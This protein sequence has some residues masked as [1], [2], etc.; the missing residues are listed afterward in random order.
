MRV[1][2]ITIVAALAIAWTPKD[3]AFWEA[4]PYDSWSKKECEK[5]LT[6]S[7]WSARHVIGEY[8]VNS[9]RF[10]TEGGVGSAT[11]AD[12]TVLAGGERK[13]EL[14]FFFSILSA[15]PIRMALTRLSALEVPGG[16]DSA[17][18]KRQAEAPIPGVI[19]V[20]ID[21]TSEPMG[22]PAIRDFELFFEQASLGFFSNTT[23]LA[24]GRTRVPIAQ[25]LR[26]GPQSPRPVFVFPRMDE[27]GQ[28]FFTGKTESLFLE[29]QIDLRKL[30]GQQNFEMHLKFNLSKM[31]FAGELEL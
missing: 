9:S 2:A 20:R 30:G 4:K 14:M 7:P 6:D 18:M 15:R 25:Y 23:Y 5:V 10:G 3:K 31:L 1:A 16:T 22:H 12:P 29:T 13:I 8:G 11:Q 17:G 27:R 26:P 21:Y 19:L 24:S 28:P